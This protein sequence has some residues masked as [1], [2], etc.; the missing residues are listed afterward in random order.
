M[1]QEKDCTSCK[2]KVKKIKPTQMLLIGLSVYI[3]I[4][5]LYGTYK[6]TSYLIS[7]FF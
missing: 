2:K 4:S 1:K 7:M 6:L 5:A 3:F